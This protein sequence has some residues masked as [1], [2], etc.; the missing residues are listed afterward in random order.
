[1]GIAN[2]LKKSRIEEVDEDEYFT[3]PIEKVIKDCVA[4]AEYY[5]TETVMFNNLTV[6]T[7]DWV[8]YNLSKESQEL[9]RKNM[10][11]Y[12]NSRMVYQRLFTN[13]INNDIKKQIKQGNLQIDDE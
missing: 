2:D 9:I 8:Y 6:C 10:R 3:V 13:L 4:T 1:M 7:D 12:F 11:Q 5:A